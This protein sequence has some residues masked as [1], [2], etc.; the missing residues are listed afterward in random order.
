MVARLVPCI[1][2]TLLLAGCAAARGG[3]CAVSSPI[4]LSAPTVAALSDA[5]VRTILVHNR[6]G[7]ALCGWK[8]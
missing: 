8:P 2:C 3:F 1:F 4:R 5:E 7:A 6:K